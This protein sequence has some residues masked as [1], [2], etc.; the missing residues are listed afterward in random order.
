ML[1]KIFLVL[2]ILVVLY[3]ISVF[4]FPQ[5]SASVDK[6]IG[7]PGLSDDIRGK[8]SEFDTSVSGW[9]PSIDRVLDSYEETLS[10]AKD[11]Q[12]KLSDGIKTTKDTIDTIRSGAQ[13]VEDTYNNARESYEDV[14]ETLSGAQKKL[15]EVQWVVNSLWEL[16]TSSGSSY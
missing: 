5:I 2:V 9:L 10:G 6:L 13:Q 8:K 7:F 15:E 3:G 4:M 1:K 14:K 16:T 12:Q 11:V